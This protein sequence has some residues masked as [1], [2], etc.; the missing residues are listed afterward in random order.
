M[1]FAAAGLLYGINT[2]SGNEA[3]SYGFTADNWNPL[4]YEN[5]VLY[6]LNTP[7]GLSPSLVALSI[8]PATVPEFSHNFTATTILTLSLSLLTVEVLRK[9]ATSPVK[10]LGIEIGN[11]RTKRVSKR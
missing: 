8:E 1:I 6:A 10:R 9:R 11:R 2:A 5:G 3:W 7:N 4:A